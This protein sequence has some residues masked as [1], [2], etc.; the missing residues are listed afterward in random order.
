MWAAYASELWH[1]LFVGVAGAAA[2]LT[3]LLFVSLSINLQQILKQVWLPRRAGLTV[4][5]LVVAALSLTHWLKAR[6][7]AAVLVQGGHQ[8]QPQPPE[9]AVLVGGIELVGQPEE[10][11]LQDQAL[12]EAPGQDRADGGLAGRARAGQGEQRQPGERPPV[13]A[14]RADQ[15]R[16]P[17]GDREVLG[18]LAAPVTDVQVHR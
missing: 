13:A 17:L 5:L 1:E 12:P 11:L 7:R 8:P 18:P 4:M 14:G 10:I 6:I 2:A 9:L 15:R 16:C 3:G